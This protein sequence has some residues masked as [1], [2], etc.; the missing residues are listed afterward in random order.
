MIKTSKRFLSIMAIIAIGCSFFSGVKASS[1]YMKDSAWKYLNE[2]RLADIQLKST[3]GFDDEDIGAVADETGIAA[4]MLCKGYSSDLFADTEAGR[5]IVRAYSYDADADMDIPVLVEGAYPSADGEC[6]A[7]SRIYK[8]EQINVGDRIVLSAKSGDDISDVLSRTEYTVTGLVR[9]PK[10]ISYERGM[11]KLGNGI[12]NGFLYIPEKDFSYEA[13]TDLYIRLPGSY[14]AFSEEYDSAAEDMADRLE[15]FAGK[16]LAEKCGRIRSDA[17]KEMS[18]SREELDRAKSDYDKAIGAYNDGMEQIASERSK[19]IAAKNS[20]DKSISD[21]EK[22]AEELREKK[23]RLSMLKSTSS[24]VS[25]TLAKYSA[26]YE[27]VL[28]PALSERLSDVQELYEEFGISAPIKD[29]LAI[30]IVSPPDDPSGGKQEAGNN[31]AAANEMA[32]K[33]VY[34]AE[35]ELNIREGSMN[36]AA[37]GFASA[38]EQLEQ[39][40]AELEKGEK[41][42]ESTKKQ[43][44]DAKKKIDDGYAELD[45]A[46]KEL[47]ER[48]DSAEWYVFTRDDYN[49]GYADY[50]GDTERVDAV[51]AVFPIFFILIAAL[52]CICTMTRM[53]EEQRTEIG[54]FKALGFGNVSIAAQYVLYA[55]SASIIGSAAGVVIGLELI[56]RLIFDAYSTMYNF[57]GIETPVRYDY[58][59]G[60]MG[61]SVLCTSLSALFAGRAELAQ[62][63][64]ALMRP[65]PPASGRRILLERIAPVWKRMSFTRKVTFRNIFRYKIKLIMTVTGIAGCTALLIAAFGLQ[66]AISSVADRQFG[67]IFRYDAAAVI[68]DDASADDIS[69]LE[70]R[71]AASEYTAGIL[72]AVQTVKDVS[73]DTYTA[74]GCYVCA[75]REPSEINRFIAL[76]QRESGAA[77]SIP[78]DKVIINEKLARLLGADIGGEIGI[79]GTDKSFA[80][81]GITE[82]YTGNYVYMSPA[83]YRDAFGEYDDNIVF[84]DLKSRLDIGIFTE[85]LLKEDAVSAVS[86]A[87]E[88]SEKFHSLV[89]SLDMIII[90]VIGFAGALAMVILFNLASINI[91][92]R[93]HELATIKVLGFFDG[94][95]TSYILRENAISTLI[96]IVCGLFPG[97]L[98]EKFIIRA[99]EV[100]AVMFSPE[101]PA[102]CY[103]AAAAV[104]FVFAAVINLAMHFGLKKIDMVM[105]L[106]AVE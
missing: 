99:S 18:G 49:T 22:G 64:A 77:L 31:A 24:F 52:V 78:E 60:C 106:K 65:K 29:Y 72:G 58:L 81:A 96:G 8:G 93:T 54:T 21:Y 84:L 11:S 70:G 7:D 45:D 33:Y 85:L 27:R 28:S 87:D 13:Y 91:T 48:L 2:Q 89:G 103:A 69:D 26:G 25:D 4:D 9:S 75:V 94:E 74:E 88:G 43:L 53:V 50:T 14:T 57:T 20:Y 63:P 97:A 23:R 95:V 5:L 55:A 86:S 6:L 16:R 39:Y 38:R 12:V 67:G 30:Y 71:L 15:I 1:G 61:A 37:E 17:M 104:T 102:Y 105:S 98:L 51:A 36:A 76:R 68:S 56:P 92:E 35:S 101:I 47:D 73:S 59:F 79:E 3:L 80:V 19:Y 42:L 34:S 83:L 41:K 90:M 44:D 10:Y 62:V 32:M 66:Y 40:S 46:Q 100:D 82:N